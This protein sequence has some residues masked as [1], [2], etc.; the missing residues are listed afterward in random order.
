MNT[1]TQILLLTL[2]VGCSFSEGTTSEPKK[3]VFDSIDKVY[4]K[5]QLYGADSV[6]L[7]KNQI[8][9]IVE[10]WNHSESKGLHK[11]MPE[12]WIFVHLKN[13]SIR[14]F[15]V[16]GHLIKEDGDGVFSIGDSLLMTSFWT[17]TYSFP[18]PE[19]YTPLTFIKSVCQT[20]WTD[21]TRLNLGMSM[22]N[23]FPIDWVIEE[24]VE[25]LIKLLDSQEECGCFLNPLSS[26]IPT[27]K[28]E[29]GGYAGIFLKSLIY[30]EKVDLELYGCP[31]VDESLNEELR[32]WWKERKN[33]A[34]VHK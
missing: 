31:K 25:E 29:K 12:F 19:D 6:V 22:I 10:K 21:S 30:Q 2:F 18:K 33:K 9:Q 14:K 23:K 11:M 8:G 34:K 1:I 16:N 7:T 15:S 27:G 13:D 24:H 26:H 28:A 20:I 3:L 4:L 32:N 17:P 5:S